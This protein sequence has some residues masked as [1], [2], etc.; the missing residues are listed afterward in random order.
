MPTRPGILLPLACAAAA[1]SAVLLAPTLFDSRTSA[2]QT[3]DVAWVR[4]FGT[5]ADDAVADI[6]V[7]SNGDIAVVGWT[8]GV[9]PGEVSAGGRDVFA[10]QYTADGDLV[11][12]HQFGTDG[13]DTALAADVDDAGNMLVAGQ[14]RGALPGQ[15]AS[16]AADAFVRAYERTGA[17]HWT[18]QFGVS[19]FG[20]TAASHVRAA[21]NGATL[22]AG[23]VYGSL[24][25]QSW[26]GQYDAFVRR[27]DARA[28]D[29][30]VRQFGTRGHDQAAALAIGP[31][32]RPL[33]AGL[34]AR[35]ESAI[36]RRDKSDPILWDVDELGGPPSDVVVSLPTLDAGT[37][38]AIRITPSVLTRSIVMAGQVTEEHGHAYV[39]SVDLLGNTIWLQQIQVSGNDFATAVALDASG[40]VY[41]GGNLA[42]IP[43]PSSDIT[44]LWV[45]KYTR[46]GNLVWTRTLGTDRK[47]VLTA[48]AVLPNGTVYIAGWTTGTFSE[49]RNEGRSD[50]FVAKLK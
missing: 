40:D 6:A 16:G 19:G 1:L 15:T 28:A 39:R 41:V 42:G 27:F 5:A 7:S 14:V 49:Q 22:V 29:L 38:T 25:G 34:V 18:R 44:H 20:E 26:H 17:L 33:V 9:L 50:A 47:D 37:V 43:A 10:R 24:S 36:G 31:R 45:Q 35:D 32:G 23:W 11:W 21:P 46:D 13:A 12:S 30:S 48:L 4:Q 3:S 2:A 8:H